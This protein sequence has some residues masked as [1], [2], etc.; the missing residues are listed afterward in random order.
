MIMV[1]VSENGFIDIITLITLYSKF[2]KKLYKNLTDRIMKKIFGNKAVEWAVF[3]TVYIL[4]KL[5]SRMV[6]KN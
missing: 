3:F 1:S 6:L 4:W 5:C 2:T